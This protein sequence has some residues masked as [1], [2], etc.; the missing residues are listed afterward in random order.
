MGDLN[1]LQQRHQQLQQQREELERQQLEQQIE[2]E[3]QQIER[4]RAN[5]GGLPFP[6]SN[7]SDSALSGEE[8]QIRR[9]QTQLRSNYLRRQLDPVE[10]EQAFEI[11][12]SRAWNQHMQS[13]RR[14]AGAFGDNH[15]R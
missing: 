12:F 5:T 15:E 7:Q 9:W 13:R 1:E 6:P 10:A 8:A 11:F 14:L 4:L 2:A 3:Q